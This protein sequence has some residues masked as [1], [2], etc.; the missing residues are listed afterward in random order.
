[1]NPKSVEDFVTFLMFRNTL[2]KYKQNGVLL[3]V[4]KKQP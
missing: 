4:N 2:K 3:F 1:M